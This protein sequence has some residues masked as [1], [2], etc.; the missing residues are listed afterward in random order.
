MSKKIDFI[1][2]WANKFKKNPKKY[3]KSLNEFID[4]QI[5]IANNRLEKLDVEKLIEIFDI[6]NLELINKLKN[7]TIKQ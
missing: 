4:S 2:F 1:E 7:R 6:K 3:L 5:E